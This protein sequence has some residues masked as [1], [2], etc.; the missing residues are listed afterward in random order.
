M[1]F[2]VFLVR[3]RRTGVSALSRFETWVLK[4]ISKLFNPMAINVQRLS[5]SSA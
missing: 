3:I 5:Q 1:K 4:S 2:V